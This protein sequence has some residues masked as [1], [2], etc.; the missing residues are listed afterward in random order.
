MFLNQTEKYNQMMQLE[1]R[2]LLHAYTELTGYQSGV[3]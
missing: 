1:V 2:R 3:R